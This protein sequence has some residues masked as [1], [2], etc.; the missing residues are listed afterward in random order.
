M[1]TDLL[2]APHP[3]LK[4]P[5]LYVADVPGRVKWNHLEKV[6]QT[7]GQVRSGGRSTVAN[8][9]KKWTVTFANV[10]NGSSLAVLAGLITL[11][12]ISLWCVQRR[13]PW[14]HCKEN[15]SRG[16]IRHLCSSYLTLQRCRVH[17]HQTL[18]I[19]S[20]SIA[21]RRAIPCTKPMYRIYFC[22]FAMLARWPLFE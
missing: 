10:F 4:A 20:S 15:R 11:G 6:F 16:L 3:L 2:H 19:R 18:Y 21:R 9:G 5:V 17:H 12:L 7:C 22:G 14:P 1:A 8:N 13:W